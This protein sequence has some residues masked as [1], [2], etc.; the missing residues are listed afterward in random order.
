[1][2]RTI[3]V[4][5]ALGVLLGAAACSDDKSTKPVT[6]ASGT[7]NGTAW[8]L[9]SFH[10]TAGDLCLEIRDGAGKPGDGFGG[11][12]GGWESSKPGHDEDPY[13]DGPGPGGSEFAFGPLGSAV[14]TV[15]ATA[16]GKQPLVAQAK[17]LPAKAGAAKFFVLPL[18][19]PETTWAY[20]GKG[21]DGSPEPLGL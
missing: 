12:C 14:A 3:A 8:S 20:T 21:A 19:D 18:P 5:A 4:A 17:P 7:T 6:V 15:E 16:P 10:N 1:M 2:R 11:G 9:V 13:V